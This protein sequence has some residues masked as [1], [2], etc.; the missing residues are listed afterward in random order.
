MHPDF[1]KYGTPSTKLIEECAEVIQALC[2]ADRFGLDDHNPVTLIANRD[3]I[4]S[5]ID[6]LQIAINNFQEWEK[7]VPLGSDIKRYE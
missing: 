1:I 6:D 5:E 2:K 3:A 7:S 4:K